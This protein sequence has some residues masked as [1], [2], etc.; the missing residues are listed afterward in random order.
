MRVL[1]IRRGNDC[2]EMQM[3]I[4]LELIYST[5][6]GGNTSVDTFVKGASWRIYSERAFHTFYLF[7]H[8]DSIMVHGLTESIN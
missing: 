8:F 2:N 3:K 4:L 6:S 7:E 1:L 5:T